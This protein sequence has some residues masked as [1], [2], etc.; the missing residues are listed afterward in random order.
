M[1]AL[2]QLWNLA[3][4]IFK[5]YTASEFINAVETDSSPTTLNSIQEE[6]LNKFTSALSNINRLQANFYNPDDLSSSKLKAVYV[7][8]GGTVNA[9][10]YNLVDPRNLDEAYRLTN[11]GTQIYNLLGTFSN[12]ADSKAN[13]HYVPDPT[14]FHF[15]YYVHNQKLEDRYIGIGRNTQ[16]KVSPKR[17]DHTVKGY[18]GD[19]LL[20]VNTPDSWGIHGIMRNNSTQTKILS[21]LKIDTVTDAVSSG[22]NSDPFELYVER[23]GDSSYNYSAQQYSFV[24]IGKGISDTAYIEYCKAIQ[25]LQEDLGRG[26]YQGTTVSN[27]LE[28]LVRADAASIIRVNTTTLF[29]VY[30]GYTGP[31]LEDDDTASIYGCFSYDNGVSWGTPY[32]VIPSPIVSGFPA[33]IYVPSLY[34][35]N[36]GNYI[37]IYTI[38]N[39]I[40]TNTS[41]F[42]ITK[43]TD[44]CVTWGAGS[45][46]FGETNTYYSMSQD[47]I[48]KTSSGKLLYPFNTCLERDI[49]GT[50]SATAH[51]EGNFLVSLDDGETWSY[52]GAHLQGTDNLFVESGVYELPNKLVCYAR[53]RSDSIWASDSTDDGV[54]WSAVY[55][56]GLRAPNSHTTIIYSPTKNLL[57]A[58]HNKDSVFGS[59]NRFIMQLSISKELTNPKWVDWMEIDR[60]DNITETTT[61]F[62]YFEPTLME[63]PNNNILI[64]YS[65]QC[66]IAGANM[67]KSDL[68][69]KQ[70]PINTSIIDHLPEDNGGSYNTVFDLRVVSG[71]ITERMG[72]SIYAQSATPPSISTEYNSIPGIK[73]INSRYYVFNKYLSGTDSFLITGWVLHLDTT[74]DNFFLVTNNGSGSNSGI[75]LGWVA[76]NTYGIFA[77]SSDSGGNRVPTSNSAGW[78][79]TANTTPAFIALWYDIY[80]NRFLLFRNGICTAS[81]ILNNPGNASGQFTTSFQRMQIGCFGSGNSS[82]NNMIIFSQTIRYGNITYELIA[83]QFLAERGIYGV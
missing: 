23:T 46:I 45:K 52:L 68:F 8:V 34:K 77:S 40:T 19:N 66:Q 7:N 50:G 38:L 5:I 11:T 17:S 48:L 75:S 47:R 20:S 9:H 81:I 22:S 70:I 44:N 51:Y 32:E 37:L 74:H 57:L 59:K 4:S 43:S 62:M 83:R 72:T 36:N 24:S 56:L 58:A 60:S 12:G 63:L 73:F 69:S 35:Q 54:T 49:Y 13:T 15:L 80:K 3:N 1:G 25:T 10:K 16:I 79:Y 26:K 39:P 82:S 28:T 78:S 55:N 31:G 21:H 67:N 14:D 42:F 27:F 18:V 61:D 41:E 71:V 29:A 65:H 76:A 33:T 2:K 53:N 64:M 6:A 30:N